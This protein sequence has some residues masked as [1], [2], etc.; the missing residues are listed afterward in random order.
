MARFVLFCL[1]T[2]CTPGYFFQVKQLKQKVVSGPVFKEFDFL[3]YKIYV[4]RNSKNNDELTLKFAKKDDIWLHAK[5]V[6]GSHVVIKKKSGQT[7]PKNVIEY[8]AVLAGKNSK[9]KSDSICP[10][11]VT[12]KKF[13][14]KIKGAPAG[15]VVVDREEV[16]L[17]KL[18]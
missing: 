6:A 16:I 9:R 8:A 15:S 13:V 2:E 3:G 14:R 1:G 5:D 4:G 18:Y 10:I 11:I 7:V 17:V 12:P